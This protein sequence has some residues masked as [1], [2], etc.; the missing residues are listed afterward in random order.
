MESI[1]PICKKPYDGVVCTKCTVTDLDVSGLMAAEGLHVQTGN[2]EDGGATAFLVDLVSNRKI[3]ITTPRCKVGRDDLN[4]IVISGDQSI[5]RFHFVITKEGIEYFVQDG[6]SRHGTFLNGNQITSPEPIHDGD[7]L[8]VGVSLFW[9]VIENVVPEAEPT[10]PVLVEAGRT[11]STTLR[12]ETL[13]SETP[14]ESL[15][16]AAAVDSLAPEEY[17]SLGAGLRE[18]GALPIVTAEALAEA[19]GGALTGEPLLYEEPLLA[20]PEPQSLSA[21]ALPALEPASTEPEISTFQ[22]LLSDQPLPAPSS[23]SAELF[24]ANQSNQS[25]ESTTDFTRDFAKEFSKDSTQE[26]ASDF[27]KDFTKDSAKDSA[28]EKDSLADAPEAHPLETAA[29]SRSS[30]FSLS[31]ALAGTD[32]PS[33]FV[34]Q[35]TTQSSGTS[36]SSST[37]ETQSQT[38]LNKFAEVVEEASSPDYSNKPDKASESI[39]PQLISEPAGSFSSGTE[40]GAREFASAN[41]KTNSNGAKSLMTTT[42]ESLSSGTGTVPEWCNRYFF[43][44]LNRLNRDLHEYNEQVR[45]A[46]QKIKEIEGRLATTR[47][48][49]NVLLTARGDELV[50]GCSRVLN[51]LGWRSRVMEEDK[52]ELRVEIDDKNICIA[53]IVWTESQADRSHLGQLSI[54]QTKYWCDQGVEPKGILVISR[55][56]DS[57]PSP[58]TSSDMSS[59][60]AEYASKKNVCLLTTLQLLA[61]YKEIA[62]H[63][64]SPEGVRNTIVATNGWLPGFHLEPTDSDK[65]EGTTN[66]LSSLLSA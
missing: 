2:Q 10:S 44:E 57:G 27:T 56:T 49:R 51:L 20:Q 66:K 24:S 46:Q 15:S 54:S 58:L 8:K 17:K 55:V 3:P 50:E 60:L 7:V 59:D 9:F 12:M 36:A 42:T 25:F 21:L 28:K 26:S 41:D 32:E 53:R 11:G 35:S 4:D 61:I 22:A 5:S 33:N 64:G 63:D 31:S 30:L 29:D 23:P 40:D 43:G 18:T 62:L 34:L 47:G 1:C 19:S 48:V 45:V 37:S 16:P 14:D 52:N 13:K 39:L 6:K 38:T 65:D